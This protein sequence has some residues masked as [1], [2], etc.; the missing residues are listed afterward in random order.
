MPSPAAS[1]AS[2]R[3]V[4]RRF[5]RNRRGSAAVEFALV[6]PV[7]FAL[8]FAIIETAIVFFAGQVLETVTQDAARMIMTGQAQT[9]AYTKVQ[10]KNYVCG[11]ISVLFDCANGIYV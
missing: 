2:I 8:L 5:R 6:A 1:T 3:T 11:R 9:A 10:F 7:F 4:L